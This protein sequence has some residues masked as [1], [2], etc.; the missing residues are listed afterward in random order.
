M[1][2]TLTEAGGEPTFIRALG[3]RKLRRRAFRVFRR[4]RSRT[5]T[6]TGKS[7]QRSGATV[8]DL[9]RRSRGERPIDIMDSR[10]CDGAAAASGRSRRKANGAPAQSGDRAA[11]IAYSSPGSGVI[12]ACTIA[13]ALA[14]L[15]PLRTVQLLFPPVSERDQAGVDELESQTRQPAVVPSDR[16]I[17]VRRAGSVQ[18]ARRIRRRKQA[19]LSPNCAQR[20]RATR[21]NIS[22]AA[23]PVPAIQ[24][25]QAPVFY[26]YA[27]AAYAE[28]A[29]PPPARATRS[30]F[31]ESRCKDRRG[32]RTRAEQRQRGWRKRNSYRAHRAGPQRRGAAYGF[33]AS[34][35][36]C[37]S[38]R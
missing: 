33:G 31:C 8:I 4:H 27:F 29:A 7:A 23:S 2:G 24:L 12:I 26:G 19:A 3:R 30:R 5:R 6:R 35:I 18:P 10:A 21:L 9:D 34:L 38:R 37:V 13:A 36:I 17:R 15:S 25:V 20:S 1:A 32:G 22:P 28:F 11:S 16:A 14:K